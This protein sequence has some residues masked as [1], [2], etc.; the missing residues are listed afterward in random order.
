MSIPGLTSPQRARELWESLV[1]VTVT[2][3]N[4]ASLI[5]PLICL[6][7]RRDIDSQALAK[8][9]L[10]VLASQP[11]TKDLFQNSLQVKAA[12]LQTWSAP[13]NPA[14]HLFHLHLTFNLNTSLSLESSCQKLL[15]YVLDQLQETQ[16]WS[17]EG[18]SLLPLLDSLLQQWCRNGGIWILERQSIRKLQGLIKQAVQPC[19]TEVIADLKSKGTI[20]AW[21]FGEPLHP[22]SI[23]VASFYE[24]HPYPRWAGMDLSPLRDGLGGYLAR[25]VGSR[26]TA[27]LVAEPNRL[28]VLGCGT[29]RE[30][31]AW[32]AALPQSRVVGVDLSSASLRHANQMAQELGIN[33]VDWHQEDL[34]RLP[35]AFTDYDLVIA[36]GVLHHLPD[37][38]AGFQAVT[39]LVRPGGLIKLALYSELA[40]K[41]LVLAR[42]ILCST[43][44]GDH[45]QE[46][47]VRARVKLI[48][49]LAQDKSL[50]CL[51][52]IQEFFDLDG[53]WDLF[54]HPC[55]SSFSLSGIQEVMTH[56]KLHFLGF[57][58]DDDLS[59]RQFRALFP[60]D[61]D[62][63]NLHYWTCF[64]ARYTQTFL[65][66]YRFWCSTAAT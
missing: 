44:A 33:N 58:W 61:P 21:C 57:E 31:L 14:V 15:A 47:L 41:P 51:P 34:L 17:R 2:K 16:W 26:A 4:S 27:A 37:P 6:L 62:A 22:T 65:G 8:T 50:S 23:D 30:A 12:E 45:S 63:V 46:A 10:L 20:K 3:K 36:S 53:C 49:Q 9:T 13:S 60:S 59:L 64:E 29:G 52:R 5:E 48:E 35:P 7:P 1:H 38:N 28:L 40:R 25:A 42:E 19:P 43:M 11:S 56:F 66:M 18:T 54:F 32:A 24:K 55:E 39:R